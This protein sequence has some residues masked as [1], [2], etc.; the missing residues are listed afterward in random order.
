MR[1]VLCLKCL[2]LKTNADHCSRGFDTRK[3]PV[4]N[5]EKTKLTQGRP[6]VNSQFQLTFFFFFLEEKGGV[7]GY[8]IRY[9]PF[10]QVLLFFSRRVERGD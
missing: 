9:N 4:P 8:V 2:F 3:K 5:I 1:K 6:G 7:S 10:I